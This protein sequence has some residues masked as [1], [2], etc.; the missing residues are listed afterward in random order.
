MQNII[1]SVFL[2]FKTYKLLFIGDGE[3]EWEPWEQLQR[4]GQRKG[5]SE[6]HRDLPRRWAEQIRDEAKGIVTTHN[7]LLSTDS[8]SIGKVS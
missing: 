7:L 3:G 8:E 1:F 2:L 4:K 6:S 5:P